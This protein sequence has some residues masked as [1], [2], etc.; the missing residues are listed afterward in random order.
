MTYL[1]FV[2]FFLQFIRTLK[3]IND[4]TNDSNET[5][6]EFCV[7]TWLI[8]RFNHDQNFISIQFLCLSQCKGT[9]ANQTHEKYIN[10]ISKKASSKEIISSDK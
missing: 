8:F 6:N 7:V 2:H 3:K 10:R 1:L 5:N 9:A 4:S